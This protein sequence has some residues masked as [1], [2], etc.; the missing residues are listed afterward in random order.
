MFVFY[1]PVPSA[2]FLNSPYQR[3][4][5]SAVGLP[6]LESISL[7]GLTQCLST[8]SLR[9]LGAKEPGKLEPFLLFWLLPELTAW[10][11]CL[12]SIC[13]KAWRFCGSRVHWTL[14]LGFYLLTYLGFP[15]RIH[16]Q[17]SHPLPLPCLPC[18]FCGPH[19]NQAEPDGLEFV[20]LGVP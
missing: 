10:S 13:L 1:A 9:L 7:W 18:P 19:T 12:F 4:D 11:E 2:L 3:K 6:S 16:T 5:W 17:R 8:Y 20:L 15:S 14:H